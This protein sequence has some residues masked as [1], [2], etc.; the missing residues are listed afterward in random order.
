MGSGKMVL[1]NLFAGQK[2]RCRHREWT[3]RHN[4]GWRGGMNWESGIQTYALPCVKQK[5]T[6]LWKAIK[7]QWKIINEKKQSLKSLKKWITWRTDF[8]AQ[9][10]ENRN[11]SVSGRALE[12]DVLTRPQGMLK[13]PVYRLHLSSTVL[14]VQNFLQEFL[15]F[16]SLHCLPHALNE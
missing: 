14:R 7:L 8:W 1:M 4:R 11:Q 10:A 5:L 3:C 2:Q 9:P 6:Q 16:R 13:L 15:C 12:F